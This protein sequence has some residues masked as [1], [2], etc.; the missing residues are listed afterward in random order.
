[1]RIHIL[2]D[3][4]HK[5]LVELVCVNLLNPFLGSRQGNWLKDLKI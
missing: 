1:M 4:G 5:S 2:F 3:V